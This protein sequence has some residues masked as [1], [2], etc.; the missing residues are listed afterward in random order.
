MGPKIAKMSGFD[1]F[2]NFAQNTK[3]THTAIFGVD[4]ISFHA[5]AF[6]SE[7]KQHF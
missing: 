6:F 5:Q 2:L 3:R 7:K 1:H 4:R